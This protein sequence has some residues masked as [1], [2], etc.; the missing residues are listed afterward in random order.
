MS[1]LTRRDALKAAALIGLTGPF[2]K[3]ATHNA[4]DL[5]NM[6]ALALAAGIRQKKISPVEVIDAIYAR[7][8]H[9][10]PKLN[11]Y[12]TLTEESARLAAKQ[13]EVA[14]MRGEQLGP[15]HG[16]PVSIKD[17]L[18][19]AGVRTM[20]GS[21][22]RE[23]YVPEEDA[24]SV[25]RLK[26]AGAIV[27]GKTTSPEF[28]WK[29]VTDS[30]LTGI[31]RNPW[32]LGRTC[33][34]SSGGAA[35]AVASGM[36]PLAVGTD[37]GGS[38]RIPSSFCGLFG[39][40]PS[41]GRVPIYPP[42]PSA[43]LVHA[44]PITRTVS[45]AALMLNVMSGPDERDLLSLPAD[46]TDYLTASKKGIKG[47]RVAWSAN[48]GCAVVDPEVARISEA[49]AKVFASD[50]GCNLET[51]DPGFKDPG[52][53]F[54]FF[55]I[56]S[57]G[58]RLL[59]LLPEW[60]SRMDPGLVALAKEVGTLKAIDYGNA[61]MQ[62]AELWEVVRKF[63]GRYDLLLTPT[64]ATAAFETGIYRPVEISGKPIKRAQWFLT[65]PFNLTG[66]PA[67]S[68]P[69]GFTSEGLPVGLQIVGPRFADAMVL[70]ASAA[71]EQAP[72]GR[73]TSQDLRVGGRGRALST[74]PHSTRTLLLVFQPPTPPACEAA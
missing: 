45:D 50:L 71:F 27:L 7:I 56:V 8:H 19:T 47:L 62:R 35:A 41:L 68:V 9:I 70:R 42:N 60:E 63:F 13:A 31:T 66:Q 43:I 51:A 16:V 48:L 24:P 61:M 38:I 40:N 74:S 2:S 28:G 25:A 52:E 4:D 32:N 22:I 44:G 69:C 67:A 57:F 3:A 55:W 39:L 36:G 53:L 12:C 11:A 65:H 59:P 58:T 17:L 54:F 15:L 34:G 26:A 6:T 1:P 33:G 21:K 46:P 29:G 64:V 72:V 10:N 73:P 14:V 18:N 23:L 49:A 5:C 30:P 37:G 20:Y